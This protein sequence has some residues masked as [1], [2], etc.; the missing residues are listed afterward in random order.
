M[1]IS[2]PFLQT[3][4]ANQTEQAWL[5]LIMPIGTAGT[6]HNTGLYPVSHAMNWH[7]GLHLIAPTDSAESQ[8]VRA[9]ADGTVLFCRKPAPIEDSPD[10]PLRYIG[11][12][13]HDGVVVIKHETEI[14]EGEEAKVTFYSV[15][16]HLGEVESQIASG[17]KIYRKDPIGRGGQVYGHHHRE[18]HFEIACDDINLKRLVGRSTSEL[19]L[20]KDGR[21][22][23]VFG[24][25]HF[26]L[27]SGAQFYAACPAANI[28]A[29]PVAPAH[30]STDSLFVTLHYAAGEADG[31]GCGDATLCTRNLDGTVIGTAQREPDAEYNLYKTANKLAEAYPAASRPAPSAVYELIR[32]GRVI[33]TANETLTPASMPHWRKVAYPGGA[34]WVNLNAEGVKKFSD[35]DF[36][37]WLG[38]TLVDDSSD[39]NSRCDSATLRQWVTNGQPLGL[40]ALHDRINAPE[41]QKKLSRAICKFPSE[42]DRSTID[43]RYSWLKQSTEEI[44]EALG[45]DDYALFKAHAEALC[46]DCA[47]LFKAQWCFSPKSFMEVFRRC[48]WLSL[49]ELAST[50][51]RHLFYTTSG[52]P[53]SAITTNNSIFCL[54]KT[55]AESR[56]FQ[57]S[58]ELNK[59][60]RKY[61]GSSKNRLAI[62]LS[63]VL[64]ETA[65]WRNPGGTKRLMHEWG[66]GQYS[67][68]NPATEHYSIFYGRGIMQLTWAGNYKAYGE[69]RQLANNQG[70]YTDR[71]NQNN[72]RI[73]QTSQ[74]YNANPN[75]GGV[76]FTW[77]PRYD[78]DLIAENAYAACD[79]GGFYWVSKS[80]S[81]GL[82]INRA[83]DR[84]YSA[85]SVGL[86]N[87]LV[88]GGSNGYYERQAYTAYCMKILRD[89]LIELTE[90]IISPP[91]PKSRVNANLLR[92]V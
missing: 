47:E 32:F 88:N 35:A 52:N 39:A 19:D 22:D 69:Y 36:P 79:S 59:V 67:A 17:R 27:P 45:E 76:L 33:N 20:S 2:P 29:P 21:A 58:I 80:Y 25:L 5:D 28:S 84:E 87:R 86:V 38:W 11:G 48:G 26:Y 4:A 44:P 57:H 31:G 30:T 55:S 12:W 81:S 82:N 18:I 1:L 61:I 85:E 60:I 7:G 40:S 10:H 90:E 74:H 83:C 16:M 8:K 56:V 73:S 9:I 72:P 54:S 49:H 71:L 64:L 68:A 91:A 62:F 3:R 37:H 14:G 6:I 15:Y 65:Q 78:P 13:T 92:P 50:L 70:G 34:G 24:D 43:S 46:F 53:R 41:V 66:F 51:P 63:Q 75:D 77:A 23:A 89:G 42:W